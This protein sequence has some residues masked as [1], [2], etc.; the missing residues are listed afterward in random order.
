MKYCNSDKDTT[1]NQASALLFL[2]MRKHYNT[3]PSHF[4]QITVQI[5]VAVSKLIGRGLSTD[6]YLKTALS[7]IQEYAKLD[8]ASGTELQEKISNL[9][10]RLFTVLRDNMQITKHQSDPEMTSD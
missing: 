3:N 6:F 2:L 7:N 10:E 9:S 8:N 5:T 4:H 1:R